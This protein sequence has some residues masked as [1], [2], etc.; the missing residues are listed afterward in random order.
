MPQKLV[1]LSLT[2]GDRS[3]NF[4]RQ[5]LFRLILLLRHRKPRRAE[6]L[7]IRLRLLLELHRIG[8]RGGWE[9]RDEELARAASDRN[10]LARLDILALLLRR[11][12]LKEDLRRLAAR[13]ADAISC[14]ISGS[15]TVSTTLR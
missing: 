15:S 1:F 3:T 10:G 2:F 11:E 9:A 6:E 12:E 5:S 7:P 8:A 13:R 14:R 4:V